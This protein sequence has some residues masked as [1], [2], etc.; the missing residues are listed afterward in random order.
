MGQGMSVAATVRRRRLGGL[1]L[2]F[3]LVVGVLS[4]GVIEAPAPA[5]AADGS[6]FNAG[7]IIS[8]ATFYNSGA[9][10]PSQIQA[11]LNARVPSCAAGAVCLKNYT[12]STWTR[13]ATAYCASYP[14]VAN[15]RAADIIYAVAVACGINPQVLIVLLQKEQGLVT[16]TNPSAGKF[17]IA[18]GLR[19]PRHRPLRCAVFRLLQPGLPRRGAVRALPHQPRQLRY[20]AGRVNTI[21]WHPNAACGTSEVFIE[22]QATAGLYNYTPYRPNAAAL[23]NM[24]ALGDSCSSYGNRNFW[25]YFTDWF[26]LIAGPPPVTTANPG[27][28]EPASYLLASDAAGALWLHPGTGSGGLKPAGQVGSGW[29]VMSPVIPVGDFSGDGREDILARDG[30][31]DLWLYPRDGSGG[32][33]P[34]VYVGN[35]WQGFTWITSGGDFNRDGT[36][37]VMAVDGRGDLWLY[38]GNGASGWMPRSYL[39][40]SWQNFTSL[41]SLGDFDGDGNDDVGARDPG[42]VLWMYRGNGKG[43]WI[44]PRVEIG[45]SWQA[46]VEVS[47]ARDFS[48]DGEPD[49]LARDD[50]GGLWLYKGNGHSGWNLPPVSLGSTW[51][52]APSV[53]A[54]GTFAPKPTP[55]PSGAWDANGDSKADVLTRDA[56]G[57]VSVRPGAGT[58]VVGAPIATGLTEPTTTTLVRAGDLNNDGR[59]D[60]LS[61]DPT[62]AVWLYPGT[63]T[64][65]YGAKVAVGQ[66]WAGSLFFGVGDFSG[67]DRPDVL[68]RDARGDLWM[69]PGN[70][71][72][73]FTASRYIGSSWQ[74][75]TSVFGVGDFSGDTNPDVAARDSRGDLWLYKGNGTGGWLPRV[76][77]GS[78]WQ[79][80]TTLSGGGDLNGDALPDVVALDPTGAAWLYAGG[81]ASNWKLPRTLVV[82]GLKGFTILG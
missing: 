15:Q 38:P 79:G 55:I 82:D 57:A 58:G 14:G 33:L 43:G 76:Y 36:A 53:I 16:A 51:S 18:T 5:N 80:F 71:T 61:R 45:T 7:S 70:G 49:V 62:G 19:V 78:S 32:W 41:F 39:G 68:V 47:G 34:R 12:E 46:F 75:F 72:G 52:T 28:G 3:A 26:G 8:D 10:T 22:N 54:V 4:A 30:A 42:G 2:A 60:L 24:Y 13:P 27:L 1:A 65:N 37:D 17:R 64:G 29:G 48:G 50:V 44:L 74:G 66:N 23:A 63:G 73:G 21:L 6:Q 31:G 20:R 40:N 35:S 69:Y 56:A 59:E 11:F 81:G 25:A 67:D 9:M 77:L